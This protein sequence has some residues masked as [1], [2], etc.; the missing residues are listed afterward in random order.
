MHLGRFEI[1]FGLN[2][3]S[4]ESLENHHRQDVSVDSHLLTQLRQIT[5]TIPG[6]DTDRLCLLAMLRGLTGSEPNETPRG[7]STPNFPLGVNICFQSICSLSSL[8]GP[9]FL[10]TSHTAKSLVNSESLLFR[11]HILPTGYFV[12]ARNSRNS[13]LRC[14]RSGSRS[15]QRDS[16]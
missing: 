1:P 6:T 16:E 5:V 9:V 13:G 3:S 12:G 10:T 8:P 14:R 7:Y 15:S 2:H 4:T 11:K